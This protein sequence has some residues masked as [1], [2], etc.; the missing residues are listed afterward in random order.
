MA[1]L[2]E[3]RFLDLL[4]RLTGYKL[5]VIT[6]VPKVVIYDRWAFNRL[7]TDLVTSRFKGLLA[8]LKIDPFPAS[9]FVFSIQLIVNK[10]AGEWIWIADLQSINYA[11]TTI[12]FVGNFLAANVRRFN[13]AQHKQS[14]IIIISPFMLANATNAV[15]LFC[16][17]SHSGLCVLNFNA[18]VLGLPSHGTFH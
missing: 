3:F 5:L 8:N 17:D 7:A 4:A 10:I 9:F 11:A 16:C 13:D 14:F 18:V 12:H 2:S 15:K 6:T 1:S